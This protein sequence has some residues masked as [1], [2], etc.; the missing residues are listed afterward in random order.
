MSRPPFSG[1]P[2]CVI[3]LML[4]NDS[5]CKLD[6]VSKLI[7]QLIE[8]IALCNGHAIKYLSYCTNGLKVNPELCSPFNGTL[9]LK[10]VFESCC[11]SCSP[12]NL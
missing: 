11:G 3:D 4:H 8:H 1:I 2:I 6:F 12:C 9:N 7:Y 10:V 5:L